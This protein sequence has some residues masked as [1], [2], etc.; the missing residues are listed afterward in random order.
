[1]QKDEGSKKRFMELADKSY[2]Q[3]IYTFTEFLGL[4]EQ[5]LF[6]E[7]EKEISYVGYEKYGGTLDSERVMVRFGSKQELGYEVDYPIKCLNV[8]PLNKKFADNLTH[9]DFLGALMNLGI[10]REKL[11]DIIIYDNEAYIFCQ[12]QIEQ[13]VIDNLTRVRHTS[14]NVLPIDDKE[15]IK[16]LY[17]DEYKSYIITVD[18]K[19]VDAIVA[20]TYKISRNISVNL[21]AAGKIYI[22]GKQCTNNSQIIKSDDVISV[23]GRG[24]IKYLG[25]E[26]I[27]KKGRIRLEVWVI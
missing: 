3:G 2:N 1:M 9:R 13:Y 16:S 27:S 4:N 22:N 20:K 15:K 17:R 18:S 25:N 26:S 10:T 6:S 12:E 23:R 14:V 11:G 19:R 8:T 7:I 24:R 5:S 21:F